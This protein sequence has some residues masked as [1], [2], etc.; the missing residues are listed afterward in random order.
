MKNGRVD[1]R[2]I[3]TLNLGS[4]SLKSAYF[5]TTRS[6]SILPDS[7]LHRLGSVTVSKLGREGEILVE[8]SSATSGA[9]K[10]TQTLAVRERPGVEELLTIVS[11]VYAERGI[12]VG[13]EVVAHRIVHGGAKFS[14]P[15]AITPQVFSELKALEPLAPLHQPPQLLGITAAQHAF[16]KAR[17]IASFDT[18]FH[19]GRSRVLDTYAIPAQLYEAGVRRYGFH[20]VALEGIVSELEA[21]GRISSTTKTIVAHLGS[22]ASVTGILGSKSVSCSMGFSTLDGVPMGTRCGAIDPGVLLYLL[23]EKGISASE[24]SDTLYNLSGLLG[25]SGLSADV[26]EL[27][28]SK[29][30]S[31]E[32]A[33]DHFVERVV[34]EIGATAATLR[35]VDQLVF[36]GGIGENSS[37]I[38][39]RIVDGLA[40][41]GVR[42][43]ESAFDRNAGIDR[44][45]N[46]AGAVTDFSAPNS[47]VKVVVVRADEE[48]MLA[49]G[50]AKFFTER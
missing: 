18:A 5:A 3:L 50:A 30:Q 24:L 33:I 25:L 2:F 4:S 34:R 32:L 13:P 36:S 10:H 21:L 1:R 47:Q 14:A 29:E 31:A 42:S 9:E 44:H 46:P 17:Q 41:L 8:S 27:L 7:T 15:T 39:E 19:H 43:A 22:G 28:A 12:T 48:Q 35:G 49:R 6:D 20:G 40:W 37:V 16:P 26:R 23:S 11:R 38:R 45:Q